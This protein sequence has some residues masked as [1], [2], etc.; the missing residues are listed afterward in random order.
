[1]NDTISNS[2]SLGLDA[3]LELQKSS[4]AL[5][6]KKFPEITHL[7]SKIGTAEIASDPMGPNVSVRLVTVGVVTLLVFL[8]DQLAG[9][10]ASPAWSLMPLGVLY[11]APVLLLF[12][13]LRRWMV[14]S[15]ITSTRGL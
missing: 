8:A 2:T 6:L 7:F 14:R 5:L 15:L 1:M 4:E 3:S 11:L 13:I 9:S 10:L 12:L